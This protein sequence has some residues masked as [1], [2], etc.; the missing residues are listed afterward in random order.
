[1]RLNLKVQTA[2]PI[3]ELAAKRHKRR[4]RCGNTAFSF[5]FCAFSRL[6]PTSAIASTGVNF[7]ESTSYPI[8]M[9]D[10]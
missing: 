1:M 10:A 2:E 3:A 7:Q 5:A 6:F 4:K 9:R 8:V